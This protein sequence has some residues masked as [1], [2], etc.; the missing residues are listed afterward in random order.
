MI[1]FAMHFE[2]RASFFR[3]DQHRSMERDIAMP[4]AAGAMSA[5]EPLPN[6]SD[7]SSG[8]NHRNMARNLHTPTTPAAAMRVVRPGR[9]RTAN[10]EKGGKPL[11]LHR[12]AIDRWI[13]GGHYRKSYIIIV[14]PNCEIETPVV[15]EVEYGTTVW[16]VERC[17]RC[18]RPYG[19]DEQW[20]ED[21]QFPELSI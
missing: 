21:L 16:S 19:G 15:C 5:I 10:T 3:L 13:T 4:R 14:C 8:E 9:K 11:S 20:F 1:L 18:Y 7:G 17:P 12:S 6:T 2:R